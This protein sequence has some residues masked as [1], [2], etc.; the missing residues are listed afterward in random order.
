[1]DSLLPKPDE[2]YL[3]AAATTSDDLAALAPRVPPPIS[4]RILALDPALDE[5]LAAWHDSYAT[6]PKIKVLGPVELTV[7][8]EPTG[9]AAGRRAHAAEV[10]AYLATHPQGVTTG[11]LACDFDVQERVVHNYVSAARQWVG[12][13]PATGASFIPDCT[14]TDAGRRRGMGVYQVVGVLSDEDLF[15]RLRVR[16]QARGPE[17]IEDLV[18]ALRLV[19]G[20]PFDQLR[21]RGYGW[22]AE[23]PLD[24]QLTAAIV[25]VAHLVATHALAEEDH[26]TALWAAEQA[27]QAAPDEEKPRLDYAAA[28]AAR[29]DRE[30]SE[31][32]LD[33][34]VRSRSDDGGIPSDLPSRSHTL[35]ESPK[36]IRLGTSAE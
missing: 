24:H 1:M 14:R 9:D 18:A 6:R 29:G 27:V 5:D 25:D 36:R 11:Q 12:S 13:D 17:G 7:P 28:L 33:E 4:E 8:E 22:L 21:K 23:T 19:R 16:A 35:L 32:Y 10:V 34:E 3:A 31:R 30:H 20:R 2:E 26:E 15:R